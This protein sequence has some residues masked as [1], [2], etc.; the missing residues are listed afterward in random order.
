MSDLI[1]LDDVIEILEGIT[2]FHRN[3]DGKL[4]EGSRSDLES[5]I[6]FA[7]VE[8]KI[9]SIPAVDAVEVDTVCE[10]MEFL[11]DDSC[12]CNYNGIDEWLPY[13]CEDQEECPNPAIKYGC[14]KQFITHFGKRREDGDNGKHL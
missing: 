8:E 5:F 14:W 6:K 11:F 10:M 1:R 2:W 3:K 9:Q 13:V 12:P 7:E 4:I